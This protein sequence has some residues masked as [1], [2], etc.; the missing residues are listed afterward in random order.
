MFVAQNYAAD[1]CWIAKHAAETKRQE[2]RQAHAAA[3]QGWRIAERGGML[4]DCD[5]DVQAE[6][7]WHACREWQRKHTTAQ[8]AAVIE[9]AQALALAVAIVFNVAEVK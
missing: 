5:G 6:A 2:R 1:M 7:G 3:R 4:C 9:D 8:R